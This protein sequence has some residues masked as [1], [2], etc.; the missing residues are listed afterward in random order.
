MITMMTTIMITMMILSTIFTQVWI[1]VLLLVLPSSLLITDVVVGDQV[2]VA[3][4]IYTLR[5]FM[6]NMLD[7]DKKNLTMTLTVIPS[8]GTIVISWG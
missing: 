6:T 1:P 4:D 8:D 7:K 3:C 2:R 5:V